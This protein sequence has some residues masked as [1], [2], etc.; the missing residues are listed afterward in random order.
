MSDE[1]D[2]LEFDDADREMEMRLRV[3]FA[4]QLPRAAFARDLRGRLQQR[5]S[6]W[7]RLLGPATVPGWAAAAAAVLVVVVGTIALLGNPLHFGLG[8]G[9]AST[10]SMRAS[11]DFGGGFGPLPPLPAAKSAAG[12]GAA[13]PGGAAAPVPAFADVSPVE[14]PLT[15]AGTPAF[16]VSAPVY[17]FT[18]PGPEVTK[19]ALDAL[20]SRSG[21]AVTGGSAGSGGAEPAF[22]ATASEPAGTSDLTSAAGSFL[23]AH[24]LFPAFEVLVKAGFQEVVYERLFRL[25]DGTTVPEVTTT[26]TP[27]GTRV[28]FGNGRVSGVSGPLEIQLEQAPYP[29]QPVAAARS[30]LPAGLA[31]S[32]V[33]LVYVA[34]SDPDGLHGYFEPAYLFAAG[35]EAI[36]DAAVRTR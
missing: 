34:V 9:A 18:R 14:P 28:T 10:T 12:V 7:E 3:A 29:L 24:G 17:R 20:A 1:L 30:R 21:L 33:R 19:A 8:G 6:W 32:A 23:V 25:P 36:L 26:G 13:V 11:S 5:T 31:G 2:G 16:P 27:V 4:S 15:A 22:F 35:G